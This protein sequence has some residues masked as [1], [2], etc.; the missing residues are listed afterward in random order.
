MSTRLYLLAISALVSSAAACGSPSPGVGADGGPDGTAVP[1]IV[2]SNTVTRADLATGIAPLVVPAGATFVFD[3]DQ[4]AMYDAGNGNAPIRIAGPGVQDGVFYRTDDQN[5]AFF[6]VQSVMLGERAILRG[7]GNRALILVAD[8]PVEIHGI[9]DVSAGHCSVRTNGLDCAGPGGGRGGLATMSATGCSPGQRG[10]AQVGIAGGSGGGGFASPGG[11]GGGAVLN[12]SISVTGGAGGS[13]AGCPGPA[14]DPLMGGSGGYDGS[15][16]ASARAGGGGGGAVQITSYTSIAL[17]SPTVASTGGVWAGGAGG[18]GG[19][20]G[21]SGP[22][23]GGGGGAGGAILLEAP[24]IDIN[25]GVVLAANGG[26]GGVGGLMVDGQSGQFGATPASGGS[27]PSGCAGGAGAVKNTGAVDGT[28]ADA[29]VNSNAG[30]GG[31][32][33]IGRTRINAIVLS[34]SDQAVLSPAPSTNILPSS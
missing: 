30:G 22:I 24:T 34:V 5:R 32:G 19:A 4:G 28:S 14:L 7:V 25:P 13:G 33:G 29:A 3:T 18:S 26:G 1:S 15:G 11:A 20:P 16:P 9:I 8:G 27:G 17:V 6:A 2:A 31:G 21:G 10:N 23:S 12:A